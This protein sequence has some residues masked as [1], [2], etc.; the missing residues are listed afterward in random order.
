AFLAQLALT[1]SRLLQ[2]SIVAALLRLAAVFI[3]AAQ[4]VSSVRREIDE[5]RLELMLALALPRATQYLARLAGFVVLGIVLAAC[6]SLP[7]ALWAPPAGVLALGV[8]VGVG[9][10]V[11]GAA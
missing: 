7:L 5:R 6:F 9:P 10:G 11:V 8:S 4:V 1:E 2:A 3:I